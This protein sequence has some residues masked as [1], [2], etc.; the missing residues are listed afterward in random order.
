LNSSAKALYGETATGGQDRVV[1]NL[2][3][4]RR[5]GLHL[6]PRV[7][8]YVDLQDLMQAGMVGLIEAA[9][10]YDESKGSTFESYAYL[11]IKGAMF[12]EVRRMSHVPRSAVAIGKSHAESER[13]LS[14]KLGRTASSGELA[15]FMD[16]DADELHRE[17]AKAIHF[18]TTSIET[19]T[20]PVEN[21][22]APD[23]SRPDVQA[24]HNDFMEALTEAIERL[25]DREKLVISL[26]YVEEMNLKEIGA[27]IGVSESRVSQILSATAKSL[28]STLQLP[29]R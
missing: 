8:R 28:R 19:L 11:R 13:E 20:E 4:V 29:A 3:L 7:P 17:R 2:G 21:I 10:S 5:I 16:K 22:S 15:A 6:Q 18:E 26:Y 25:P 1:A 24:E 23:E 14:G 9:R 12:D 27:S